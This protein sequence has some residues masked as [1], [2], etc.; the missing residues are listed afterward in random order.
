VAG[1]RVL[2]V[3]VDRCTAKVAQD[4]AVPEVAALA[5]NDTSQLRT[6][7]IVPLADRRI[8]AAIAKPLV[9][10]SVVVRPLVHVRVRLD[11]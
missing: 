7:W 2:A 8:L 4:G 9:A 10:D 11:V 6:D 3:V 1:E 5:S